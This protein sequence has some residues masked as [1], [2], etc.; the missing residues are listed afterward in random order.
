M[1][2]ESDPVRIFV[3]HLFREDADYLRV[4]EYLESRDNFFY[5]NCSNPGSIPAASNPDLLRE[6]LVRQIKPAEVV[7]M[8]AAIY[9]SD[10]E[11]AGYQMDVASVNNIPV[12]GIRSFASTLMPGKDFTRR[13][14]EVVEWN[15]RSIID[16]I[17]RQARHEDTTRWDV[18]EFKLD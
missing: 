18:I 12:V 3:A 15:E 16:A 17:R 8:P 14:A 2:T 10:P 13:A 1:V 4:F 5:A 7:V 6:E 11:L 9:E